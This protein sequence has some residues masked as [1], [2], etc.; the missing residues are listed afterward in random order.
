VEG[1][2]PYPDSSYRLPCPPNLRGAFPAAIERSS[3]TPVVSG[4]QAHAYSRSQASVEHLYL[5]HADS[6]Y[7]ARD[8]NP[9]LTDAYSRSPAPVENLHRARDGNSHLTRAYS[10]SP[11][12]GGH[13]YPAQSSSR[14][15]APILKAHRTPVENTFTVNPASGTATASGCVQGFC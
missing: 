14:T 15:A 9:H 6:G 7:S 1:N 5:V 2:G 10:Q 4:Y 8:S 11:A 12:P 3:H 13:L